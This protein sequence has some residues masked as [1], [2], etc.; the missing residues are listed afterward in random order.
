MQT[1]IC[2][3]SSWILQAY[4][5]LGNSERET[6]FTTFKWQKKKKI[7]QISREVCFSLNYSQ[8]YPVSTVKCM[9][10]LHIMGVLSSVQIYLSYVYV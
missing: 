5:T 1:I 7:Q 3:P 2:Q 4:C 10:F 8:L 9:L 6:P